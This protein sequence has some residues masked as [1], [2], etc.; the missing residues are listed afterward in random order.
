MKLLFLK[1]YCSLN[2][3]L[4]ALSILLFSKEIII[5]QTYQQCGILSL[6]FH[7]VYWK[8]LFFPVQ[9]WDDFVYAAY[10]STDHFCSYIT[11]QINI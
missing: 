6:L 3:T 8:S 2:L 1:H 4:A 5:D 7:G 10:G 9:K 11:M